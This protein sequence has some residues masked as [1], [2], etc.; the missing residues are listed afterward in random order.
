MRDGNF[1]RLTRQWAL[2]VVWSTV[3][4]ACARNPVTGKNELALI[5]ESQEIEMG[6]Q[7]AQQ[8]EQSLGLVQDDQ[9]QSYVQQ[10]GA[11][12]AAD[13]ERPELPWRFRVVDDPTPNAFA[14]P[15]GF[16]Y[17]TRGM[18]SLMESEAELATVLGH[19]IG[20]VTARHS[21]NQISRAQV[22]QLG[23]G[24]GM[25]FVE[26]L[27]QFGDLAST[28]LQLLFLK[29][30]RDD[31]RQADDLGFRYALQE[32]YDVREMADV[33]QSLQTIGESSGQSPLP[34]WMSSHPDPGE[35]VS[36]AQQRVQA[37]TGVS[38][39]T[40]ETGREQYLA[41]IDGLVY[42]P[43]PRNGFFRNSTFYHPDLRFSITF[44]NGW[45]VQ[46]LPQAVVAVSPNQ[47]AAIELTLAQGNSPTA[48]ASG[49]LNQQ[50]IAAG[51]T[52]QQ[53]VNGIPAVASTFQA[54]TEQGVVQGL[55]AFFEHGGQVY[56]VIGY[57]PQQRYGTYDAAFRGALGSFDAVTDPSILNMQPNRVDVVRVQQAQTLAEFNQ[58]NPSA[59]PI[60]EAA[61]INQLSGPSATIPSGT[62]IKV[63]RA[64]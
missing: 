6:R 17:V 36:R 51:Q 41:R 2:L 4:V 34:T 44:P 35:R 33:F 16:I 39:D 15:G 21:V 60:A 18:M 24:I 5:S 30:G 52:V 62:S 56:Q 7:A 27:Q 48:A 22:A 12:L 49:F 40:L 47:D 13:S 11:R 37:L 63:V 55:A 59:I 29:Y 20:H 31:E 28:G 23:L 26:E 3:V 53:Q 58:R 50:G 19:E 64:G 8:A 38:V 61:L 43:N 10:I 54:Q 9:L 14:L 32:G 57:T 42:G 46:N 25:I 1:S 45:A